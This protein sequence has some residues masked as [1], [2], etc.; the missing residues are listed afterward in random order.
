MTAVSMG[1]TS[2]DVMR[3]A[4]RILLAVTALGVTLL[5]PVVRLSQ[6]AD[7]HPV[8]GVVQDLVVVLIPAQAVIWPQSLGWLGRWPLSVVTAAACLIVAWGLLVGGIL[9]V[10]QVRHRRAEAGYGRWSPTLWAL[11]FIV[12]VVGGSVP[13]MFSRGVGPNEPDRRT[14]AFQSAWMWSPVTGL[15]EVTRDRSWSGTSAAVTA[16]HWRAI[17][18]TALAAAPA[19]VLA[20]AQGR[21]MRA[22]RRLH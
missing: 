22:R 1:G 9:A 7:D 19:W 12:L 18:L 10:A 16:G 6:A 5:W 20:A 14:V 3:P 13:A 11:V 15:Y 8:A 17:G 21:G 4:T 2:P